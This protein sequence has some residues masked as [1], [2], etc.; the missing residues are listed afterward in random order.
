MG[1][2]PRI[3][4]LIAIVRRV[5]NQE[6]V[7]VV[8]ALA[9]VTESLLSCVNLPKNEAK[10][11]LKEVESLHLRVLAE[12]FPKPSLGSTESVNYLK[13]T[14]SQ[15]VK[16][17][18]TNWTKQKIDQ[19]IGFGEV[20]S[21]DIVSR[22]LSEAGIVARQIVAT[23]LIVTDSNFGSAEFMPDRTQKQVKAVL[24]PIIKQGI[25]PVVTG[26]IGANL[27]GETTTLGRGGSDY[28]ASILGF[29]LSASEVQIWTDVDGIFTADPRLVKN[30]KL[31]KE[32]SFQEASEMAT[33][34]AKVLHPRTIRPAIK[35]NIPVRVL[36]TFNPEARGTLITNSEGKNLGIKAVSFKRKTTLINIYSS[37]M[38]FS[39][40]FLV[41]IF[42]VFAKA[43]ISIDLVSVSEVSVSVTLD[44]TDGVDKAVSELKKFAK[45]TVDRD[46]G[47]LSLIGEG[48]MNYA[49]V[50]SEVLTL[51]HKHRI[52]IKMI[53]FGA[54]D[55]NI[56]LVLAQVDLEKAVKLVHD[57][58]VIKVQKSKVKIPPAGRAG[59]NYGSSVRQLADRTIV[60]QVG[61][62]R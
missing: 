27:K 8:S 47:M 39:K 19:F 28:S 5:Q 31:I 34:G 2:A 50:V 40:G 51:F 16:L 54:S 13:N 52:G 36:N 49:H 25:V 35:S 37:E 61:E 1:S 6:P 26:F 29:A 62:V 46:C 42:A 17:L 33:F 58:V 60:S 4:N 23:D 7:L 57:R 48:I 10:R 45:V 43:N 21:S 15:L 30:A 20:M 11:K 56:S 44:N 9:T 24:K 3:R 22:A 18:N 53:S 14:I 41:R 59:Q 12:L 38:L 55:I 32:V